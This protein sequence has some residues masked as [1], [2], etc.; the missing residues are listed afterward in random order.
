M[1]RV[2]ILISQKI[3]LYLAALFYTFLANVSVYILDQTLMSFDIMYYITSSNI[4]Q[5]LFLKY[6]LY[7]QNSYYIGYISTSYIYCQELI[8]TFLSVFIY[9]CIL[10]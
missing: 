1:N 9:Q 4:C 5:Q 6:F 7:F 8:Y 2:K 10:V 3:S